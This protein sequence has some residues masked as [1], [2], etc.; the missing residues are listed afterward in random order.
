MV[1]VIRVAVVPRTDHKLLAVG[2][3]VA[4]GLGDNVLA[5][6]SIHDRWQLIAEH[7]R[8]AGGASQFAVVVLIA[9]TVG[10]QLFSVDSWEVCA[11]GVD[12]ATPRPLST[13]RVVA[14]LAARRVA[15]GTVGID[16]AMCA[17]ATR[18]PAH[19]G[20]WVKAVVADARCVLRLTVVTSGAAVRPVLFA[21]WVGSVFG[22]P[23]W[24]A[25]PAFVQTLLHTSI[26]AVRTAERLDADDAA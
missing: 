25:V 22:K 10:W 12:K 13:F 19:V 15:T 8:H 5:N 16:K 26:A 1:D 4:V 11:D 3:V 2:A 23:A 17:N 14:V 24:D 20:N 7:A 6:G 9:S 21:H 18:N